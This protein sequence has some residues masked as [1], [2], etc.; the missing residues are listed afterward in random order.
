[1]IRSALTIVGDRLF[2]PMTP[3]LNLASDSQIQISPVVTAADQALF[4]DVPA[5]VYATNPHWVAPLRSSE[6]K[7]LAADNPFLSYGSLQAFV[8]LKMEPLWVG[9][10]QRL[11]SG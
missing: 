10:W 2:T 7:Y 5:R 11:T 6:A 8:A 3:S 1:M 9:S 4:L